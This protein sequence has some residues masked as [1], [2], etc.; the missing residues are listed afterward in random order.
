MTWCHA[1]IQSYRLPENFTVAAL[2]KGSIIKLIPCEKWNNIR[3]KV[4]H[5]VQF[6]VAN[7]EVQSVKVGQVVMHNWELILVKTL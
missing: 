7:S 3:W 5:N 4:G 6:I 2:V 1:E